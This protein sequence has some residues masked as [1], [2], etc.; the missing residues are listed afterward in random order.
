MATPALLSLQYT[1][2]AAGVAGKQGQH[3]LSSAQQHTPHA[4]WMWAAM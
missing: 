4:P 2:A 3:N 1:K